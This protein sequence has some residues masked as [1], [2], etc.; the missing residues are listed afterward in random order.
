MPNEGDG[1][2]SAD[3]IEQLSDA[4]AGRVAAAAAS[5]VAIQ[6][7]G[8]PRSGILWQPDVVVASE[9]V[10]P[11]QAGFGIRQGGTEVGA[12][13]AGRDPGT[14]VAVLRL[15]QPL[16]GA[17]LAA[18][19][20]PRVGSLAVVLGADAAGAATARLAMVHASGPAWHSMAGGR[21]DTLLRLDG[22]LGSDEGGPVLAADG[23]LIGMSTSGPRRR[24]LVIPVAT[25]E[26][27]LE[28]LL[29]TGHV[30]RG[31]LGV[32]LQPVS[33]PSS[34]RAAAGRDNGLM[35]ISMAAGA[36]AETAGVMPGDILLELD[37][38]PAR[39][40]RGLAAVMGPERIG[41]AVALRVLRAGGVQTLRAVITAR[42]RG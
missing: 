4:L 25:I 27:V 16:T 10:L 26:R 28:P 2:M 21:I 17:H 31:W 15:A 36:P 35:V 6:T 41:Q 11:E 37:G 29:T 33:V 13:M 18:A 42:P 39:R 30:D 34:L 38:A 8:R 32:G 9:Q 40:G 5:V 23:R 3:L 1:A 24:T 14:N 22:R 20:A 7:G 12:T 19:A